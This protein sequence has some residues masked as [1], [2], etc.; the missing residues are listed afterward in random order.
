MDTNIFGAILAFGVGILIATANYIFSKHILRKR[1]TQYAMMQMVRQWIQV[2]YL[3][4]LLLAGKYTP[5]DRNWLLVGGCLGVT[6]P[7]IWFTYR[8]VKLNDSLRGKEESA[9]G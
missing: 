2:A 5:W 3:I 1:P 6:L 4:V 8:L 9:D 7:M